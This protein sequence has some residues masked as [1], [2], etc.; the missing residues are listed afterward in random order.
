MSN[1]PNRDSRESDS[2][3]KVSELRTSDAPQPSEAARPETAGDLMIIRE[4]AITRFSG[5]LPPPDV[6]AAYESVGEGFAERIIRQAEEVSEHR[7]GLEATVVASDVRLQERGQLFA[8]A[9]A[10]TALV[11]GIGLIAL[12][13]PISGISTAIIAVCTLVGM[14]VWTNRKEGTDAA[15]GSAADQESVPD[16]V[17][18]SDKEPIPLPKP[19]DGGTARDS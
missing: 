19:D 17:H 18:R 15:G 8:F 10:M 6:L 13:K 5:P 14:F 9:V 12:G 3:L 2:E 1:S 4:Q 16:E 11:G 7:R